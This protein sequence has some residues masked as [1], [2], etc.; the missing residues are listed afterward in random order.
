MPPNLFDYATSELSQDAILAYLIAWA[1]PEFAGANAEMRALGRQFL[2]A[3]LNR[4]RAAQ[5]RPEV[6][7]DFLIQSLTLTPQHKVAFNNGRRGFIDLLVVINGITHLVIEDKANAPYAAEQVDGYR[8]ALAALG[9]ADIPAVYVKSGN[10]SPPNAPPAFGIFMRGD[11]I[12]SLPDP[13]PDDCVVRQFRAY[14]AEKEAD[15]ESF[16]YVPPGGWSAAAVEGFLGWAT[17][18]L[19]QLGF[20]DA[21]WS[22]Q[23]NPD[24]GEWV[25]HWNW[26]P[27]QGPAHTVYL[28]TTHALED[29]P[30]LHTRIYSNAGPLTPAVREA[31]R[32][33]LF[34]M[35]PP[36]NGMHVQPAQSNRGFSGRVVELT[37]D[38]GNAYG[39]LPL[40]AEGLIDLEATKKRLLL[41]SQF[42][43][44]AFPNP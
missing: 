31:A 41:A 22:Y 23:S 12:A 20:P 2:L 43:N 42:L 38:G 44:A 34:A 33:I 14:L 4:A 7:A 11:L 18:L 16:R 26:R 35:G 25:C 30:R 36:Q 40:N 1:K 21:G 17:L 10:E 29:P 32:D 39:W 13:L 19:R 8:E 3:L 5:Q 28:Q 9:I 27:F 6:P 24:G 15:T 37:F